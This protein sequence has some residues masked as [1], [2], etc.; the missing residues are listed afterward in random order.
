[1][2]VEP[3]HPERVAKALQLFDGLAPDAVVVEL[4]RHASAAKSNLPSEALVRL[5]RRGRLERNRR[6]EYF[7]LDMLMKRV[8]RYAASAYQ[9]LNPKDQEDLSSAILERLCLALKATNAIDPWEF[10]FKTQCQRAAADVY[11]TYYRRIREHEKLVRDEPERSDE[12]L[13]S[14]SAEDRVIAILHARRNLTASDLEVFMLLYIH[15]IPIKAEK[16]EHDLMRMLGKP[17]GTLRESN[18]RIMKALKR[19]GDDYAQ[20]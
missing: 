12:G 15:G 16:G 20:P 14:A 18:T 17:E 8:R 6:L 13:A 7:A 2:G 11:R 10:D 3:Y 19:P 1:V 4:Q 5:I 9:S